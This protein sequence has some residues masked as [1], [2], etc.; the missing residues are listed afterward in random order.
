M[1]LLV[2]VTLIKLATIAHSNY[3]QVKE[4]C[5]IARVMR[6]VPRREDVKCSPFRKTLGNL[7]GGL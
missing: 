4:M 6:N 7:T 5:A 1:L 3:E 2:V